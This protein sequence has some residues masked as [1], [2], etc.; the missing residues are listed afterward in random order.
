[1]ENE[2]QHHGVL[3][4]KW[5]V[6]RYQNKDGTLTS[7]G[8]KR[9]SGKTDEQIASEKQKR[10]D[11]KNRGA[12]STAELQAKIQHLQLEKQLRELTDSEV[13][14]GKKVTMQILGDVGKKVIT[15]AATGAILYAGKAAISKKFDTKE[16][17]NAIFNGG[18]KKK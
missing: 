5:G 3:G 2:L 6:R 13:N 11:V 14:T 9:L 4:M 17:A 18:A 1:M 15:T 8:K 7:N 12:M 16:F 10:R